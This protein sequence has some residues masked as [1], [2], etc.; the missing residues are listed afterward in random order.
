MSEQ[1]ALQVSSKNPKFSI[2]SKHKLTLK[3]IY[4]II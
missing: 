4:I 1:D 3:I 2:Q